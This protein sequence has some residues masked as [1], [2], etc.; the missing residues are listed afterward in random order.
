MCVYVVCVSVCKSTKKQNGI[1]HLKLLTPRLLSQGKKYSREKYE[2]VDKNENSNYIFK[3]NTII[4]QFY[5][6]AFITFSV[7][8]LWV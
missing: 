5:S 7:S 2:K 3:S 1:T 8:L 4:Y 6:D